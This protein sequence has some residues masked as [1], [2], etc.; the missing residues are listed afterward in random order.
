MGERSSAGDS[1]ACWVAAS[2]L[3]CHRIG[4]RRVWGDSGALSGVLTV[5]IAVIIVARNRPTGH[6]QWCR[7]PLIAFYVALFYSAPAPIWSL[8]VELAARVCRLTARHHVIIAAAWWST[9]TQGRQRVR[10]KKLLACNV[11]AGL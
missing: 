7:A 5:L 2:L 4:R 10:P 11:P 3:K 6:A 8:V 9:A 1:L